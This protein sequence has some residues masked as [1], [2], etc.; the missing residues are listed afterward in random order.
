M[1]V[2]GIVFVC[3]S[4]WVVCS[5]ADLLWYV[6]GFLRVGLGFVGLGFIGTCGFVVFCCGFWWIFGFRFGFVCVFG[7]WWAFVGVL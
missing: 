6:L 7:V 2:I 1:F 3:D 5:L 4:V